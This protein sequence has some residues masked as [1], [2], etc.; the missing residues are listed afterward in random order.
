M[1]SAESRA[2]NRGRRDRSPA[3]VGTAVRHIVCATGNYAAQVLSGNALMVFETKAHAHWA[4][5]NPFTMAPASTRPTRIAGGV[6][7][8]RPARIIWAINDSAGPDVAAGVNITILRDVDIPLCTKR[9]RIAV[10]LNGRSIILRRL[11]VAWKIIRPY[12]ISRRYNRRRH[13]GH[14]QD[15]KQPLGHLCIRDRQSRPTAMP[16][17]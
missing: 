10:T 8:D 1:N 6:R 12:G 15:L 13:C 2:N 9:R 3:H 16:R 11:H 5:R 7:T 17:R 14:I 4:R